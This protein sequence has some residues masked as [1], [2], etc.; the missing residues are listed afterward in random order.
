[1]IKIFIKLYNKTLYFIDKILLSIW[2]NHLIPEEKLG[3]KEKDIIGKI[4]RVLMQILWDFTFGL[5]RIICHIVGCDIEFEATPYETYCLRCARKDDNLIDQTDIISKLKE[6]C[7]N[8]FI[9]VN[10]IYDFL[11]KIDKSL[12]KIYLS[13]EYK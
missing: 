10:L 1:M 4:A 11:D 13:E 6:K 7:Y 3:W 8:D 5:N 9:G 2:E 12:S